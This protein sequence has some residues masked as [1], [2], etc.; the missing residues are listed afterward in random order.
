V[1]LLGLVSAVVFV[2]G[3]ILL[4]GGSV[5][6]GLV[7]M[8][9][10]LALT[11][12]FRVAT[13]DEPNSHTARLAVIAED[14]ARGHARLAAAT[15]RAWS[16]AAPELVRIRAR[17]QRLNRELKSRLAPLGEAVHRG[18][19][20]RVESLKA[21]ADRLEL[22]I[23]QAEREASAV[24]EAVEHDVDRERAP[25]LPTQALAPQTTRAAKP[26]RPDS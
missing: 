25:I 3:L 11:A 19:D 20:Q 8:A 1:P 23:E 13:R 15:G 7:L 6:S 17:Q 22:A 14:R 16:R 24:R 18:D 4:L 9:V 26:R 21:E 10:T 2:V 12:L 5:L